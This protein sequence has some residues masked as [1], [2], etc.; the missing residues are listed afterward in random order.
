[1]NPTDPKNNPSQDNSDKSREAAANIIRGQLDNL[2]NPKPTNQALGPVP[3]D[4]T[5]AATPI[6]QP[7]EIQPETQQPQ[8]QPPKDE[9]KSKN[10]DIGP[11]ERTYVESSPEIRKKDWE[12]YQSAWQDYYQNYY[13]KYYTHH[14][15]AAQ[16]AIKRQKAGIAASRQAYQQNIQKKIVQQKEGAQSTEVSQGA[17]NTVHQTA[18]EAKAIPKKAPEEKTS[19]TS[20]Y[21]GVNQ[22]AA[23]RKTKIISEDEAAK[24]ISKKIKSKFFTGAKKVRKSRHFMPLMA[25]TAAV[26]LFLFLQ[27]NQLVISNVVAYVS[28]GNIDPQN[29]V[30]DTPENID[31]DPAPRLIIPKIN[32][33]VPV[34]Y[35]IGNDTKSQNAA[36]RDGLGHF[37]IPGASSHPGEVGNTVLSGHSS[38]DLFMQSDYKFVFAQLHKLENGDKIYAHY[39]GKRYT[40]AV[41]GKEVVYPDQVDKL[42]YDTAGKPV[43]TLITCTPLG[44]ALQRL[45]V[46]AEQISP[47]PLK[48]SAVSVDAS[49]TNGIPG[50]EP[51]WIEKVITNMFGGNFN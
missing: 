41:T 37:S 38:G 51:T 34:H 9:K 3:V 32:V 14:Y 25:A 10:P 5:P 30:I 8:E 44:T 49:S 2:F 18:A 17:K 47:D 6:S 11:Y 13:E 19:S 33:D 35:G 29:I 31:V 43:M 24:R 23:I 48:A 39:N 26:F 42:V 40:Y 45:L 22:S 4:A 7:Q 46:T 1:M 20:N 12:K 50:I 27:F 15:E 16:K 21:F 28:P 36:M